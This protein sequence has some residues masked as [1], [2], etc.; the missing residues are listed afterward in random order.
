MNEQKKRGRDRR[1]VVELIHDHLQSSPSMTMDPPAIA[2]PSFKLAM[3]PSAATA[4]ASCPPDLVYDQ[5]CNMVAQETRDGYKCCD[6]L[7]CYY[8]PHSLQP[9]KERSAKKIDEGC[10]T[11]ICGW[12]YR[13]ADHFSIDRE[14]EFVL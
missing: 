9:E 14:G 2:T 11:S 8:S 13:V 4:P 6:Y 10:R 1:A 12:M 3:V 7:R 5:L